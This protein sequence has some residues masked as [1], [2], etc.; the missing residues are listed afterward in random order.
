MLPRIWRL[1]LLA[2][3]TLAVA[4]VLEAWP[5][6]VWLAPWQPRWLAA[7]LIFWCFAY[8]GKISF[9]L[10]WLFGLISDLFAGSWLGVHVISYCAVAFLSA[11]FYRTLQLS[12]PLQKIFPA[13]LLLAGHLAYLHLVSLLFFQFNPGLEHWYSWLSSMLVWPFLCLLLVPLQ[14]WNDNDPGMP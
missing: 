1:N 10:A 11:R 13:G 14:R 7:M 3:A 4:A 6:P 9:A 2:V 5:L 8:P 12:A